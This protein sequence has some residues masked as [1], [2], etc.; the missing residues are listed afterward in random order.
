[1]ETILEIIGMIALITGCL[2]SILGVLGMHRFPDVYTRLHATGKVSAFGAVLILVAAIALT[3]LSMGKGLVLIFLILLS[4][5]A[6]SHAFASAAYRI[7][8]QPESIV[9]DSLHDLLPV[10]QEDLIDE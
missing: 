5:P 2:F 6:V 3:P 7:G 8:I 9:Q 10:N 4:A 1:M